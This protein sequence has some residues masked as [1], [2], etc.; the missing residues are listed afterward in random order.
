[1]TGRSLGEVTIAPLK[2]CAVRG[3][4]KSGRVWKSVKQQRYNSIKQDKGLRKKYKER[5]A[6]ED[7]VRRVRELDKRIREARAA[8]KQEKRLRE[9]DRR[10]KK[11]EN[12]KR[13]EIVVPVFSLTSLS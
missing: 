10:Q 13:S 4:P 11:L 9:E 1:M 7:E 6:T 12:E 3:R 2:M 8:R 5:R